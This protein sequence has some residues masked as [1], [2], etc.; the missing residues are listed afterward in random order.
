MILESLTAVLTPAEENLIPN[1]VE[2]LKSRQGRKKAVSMAKMQTAII[3]LTEVQVLKMIHY[4]RVK[5]LVPH[6]VHDEEGNY[7]IADTRAEV[8]ECMKLIRK[9]EDMCW[10]ERNTL[11]QQM[12]NSW[13]K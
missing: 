1:F 9:V 11:Q 3:T 10:L 5:G 6:L 4:I 12:Q 7:W 2:R 13:M 8:E